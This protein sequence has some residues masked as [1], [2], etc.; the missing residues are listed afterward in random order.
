MSFQGK[1]LPRIG[2]LNGIIGGGVFVIRNE[3]PKLAGVMIEYLRNRA[4]LVC[5]N[6]RLV[7]EMARKIGCFEV[8]FENS[9]FAV[10]KLFDRGRVAET[11]PYGCDPGNRA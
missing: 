2:K 9:S 4:E 11:M 5:T 10:C 1:K 3:A 6:S 7:L 8:R